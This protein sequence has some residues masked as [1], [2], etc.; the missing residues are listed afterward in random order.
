[1]A[2]VA[3]DAVGTAGKFTGATSI[4]V[5][6]AAGTPTGV[7]IGVSFL[8]TIT[9]ATYG[10]AACALVATKT[11]TTSTIK[12]SLYATTSTPASGTQNAVVNSSGADYGS[13]DAIAVT[14]GDATTV[15][16]NNAVA[17]AA[18]GTPS[19][20]CTSAA[21]ELMMSVLTIPSGGQTATGGATTQWDLTDSFGVNGSG[22]TLNASAGSTDVQWTNSGVQSW[23]IINASFK[24]GGGG[25][26]GGSTV[27]AQLV[28]QIY[29]M[30]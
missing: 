28:K 24:E 10:G 3:V 20:S 14:N 23:A 13:M 18:S 4:T 11:D 19:A 2:Q 7:G 5:S 12:I 21:N 15:F 1:M 22:A 8:N 26:G 30:P 27:S 25:G 16:S 6:V 17:N 9:S 29:V